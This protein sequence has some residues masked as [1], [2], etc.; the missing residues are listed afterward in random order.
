[1]TGPMNPEAEESAIV[2]PKAFLV[3][4]NNGDCP[5]LSYVKTTLLL[6]DH[7]LYKE[8]RDKYK[9]VRVSGFTT[10]CSVIADRLLLCCGF[11]IG[12]PAAV[13]AAEELIAA[14]IK[15]IVSFGT[16]GGVA[17]D[18]RLGDVMVCNGALK[19]E[20]TSA[21]YIPEGRFCYPAPSLTTEI[22][23]YLRKAFPELKTGKTWTTDAPYRE[24]S[25][26]LIRLRNEDI[27]T[28]EMEASALFTLGSFR[29]VEVAAV[30][31]TG[32]LV[33]P[34]KWIPGFLQELVAGKIHKAV[35][36]LIDNNI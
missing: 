3:Y 10:S 30:M 9:A 2:S 33:L 17:P 6:Y 23:G 36:C 11:G 31:I 24:T 5:D 7:S 12:S 21:H 35:T 15:R 27:R 14:G 26:K 1:M 18:A 32:D 25:E 28:V 22:E 4:L 16:A 20:G 29:S 34:E 19:D 8:L 13:A